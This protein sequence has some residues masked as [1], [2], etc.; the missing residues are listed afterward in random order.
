[1]EDQC[2]NDPAYDWTEK[3]SAAAKAFGAECLEQDLVLVSFLSERRE[4]LVMW[5]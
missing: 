2:V 3:S 5:R 4:R 1:M